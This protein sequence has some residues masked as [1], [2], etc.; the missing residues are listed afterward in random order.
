VLTRVLKRL[1]T[2]RRHA[3]PAVHRVP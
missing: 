1:G 3:F 2:I